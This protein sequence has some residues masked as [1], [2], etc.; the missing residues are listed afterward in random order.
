VTETGVEITVTPQSAPAV[1]AAVRD[2]EAGG[3]RGQVAVT[4]VSA[5]DRY[6]LQTW[7]GLPAPIRAGDLVESPAGGATLKVPVIA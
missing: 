7:R 3:R 1:L 5:P 4:S 2:L 6:D